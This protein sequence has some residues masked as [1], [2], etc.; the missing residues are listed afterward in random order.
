MLPSTQ[1]ADIRAQWRSGRQSFVLHSSGSTGAPAAHTLSRKLMEWSAAQ[2]GTA[3]QVQASDRIFCCLPLDK[4]GGLMQVVRSEAWNIPLLAIQPALHPMQYLEERHPYSITSLTGSQLNASLSDEA[5]IARL[6]RFR[7]VLAGG[8]ALSAAA[9]QK[10]LE[11][12]IQ[13]WHTYGMTETASH[14]ALRKAGTKGFI[15]FSGVAL[16]CDARDGHLIISIPGILEQPLHT[17][18]RASVESDGSFR[19][20]GRLDTVINSGGMKIQAEDVEQIIDTLHVLRERAFVVAGAPDATWGEAVV[21]LV[22]GESF[23]LNPEQIK[24]AVNERIP[25]GAPK[26]IHFISK[27]PRTDN[28]K[29]SRHEV[30]KFLHHKHGDDSV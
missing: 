4:V 16:Q 18:D 11:Q 20:L 13:L 1:E 19:I 14:I 2:T 10:A 26:S 25:Y 24:E 9:E 21:L 6:R 5:E 8:E 22:E 28:G 3:L 15:P 30:Q 23:P 29:I 17:R 27:L 12:G 7:V